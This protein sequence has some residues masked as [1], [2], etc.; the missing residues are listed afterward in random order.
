MDQIADLLTRIRNVNA[1]KKEKTDIPFSKLKEEILRVLKDEGFI[2]NYKAFHNDNKGG[3]IRVFLKYSA[4]NEP[5][6]QGLKRVS[7]PGNRVYS[8]HDSIPK[9]RGSYGIS[10]LSTSEGVM[11]SSKAKK[12]KV[13]GEVLCQV[14]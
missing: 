11:T 14:W 1:K 8:A 3:I 4:K 13:G 7:K 2:L 5:V 10:I 12:K 6:I 9:V